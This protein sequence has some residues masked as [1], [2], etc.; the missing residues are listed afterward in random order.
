[1]PTAAESFVI[2]LARVSKRGSRYLRGLQRV[3]R[4]D[5][6]AAA[7][8]ACWEDKESFDPA[9]ESLSDWFAVHLKA[10]RRSFNGEQHA[11]EELNERL[12]VDEPERAAETQQAVEKL[13]DELTPDERKVAAL[14][15]KGYTLK[16]IAAELTTVSRL[17]LRQMSRKLKRLRDLLPERPIDR[18]APV[19][20]TSMRGMAPIDHEI[21]KMLRRPASGR[22]DCPVCW[23]CSWY[24]G[25]VPGNY[26]PTKLAD[27][28]VQA[29]VQATEAR[30]IKIGYG[31]RL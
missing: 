22:A 19:Q 8:L 27:P 3:D 15:A 21:E 24:M 7:V 20:V 25:L 17:D 9:V 23:R 11:V 4:E 29:A 14:L 30:K 26:K 13:A 28:D 10:A 5:V 6:I 1:M 31:E 16:A 2:E 18:P 12:S